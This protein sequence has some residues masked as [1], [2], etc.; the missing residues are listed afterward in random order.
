VKTTVG[1]VNLG[2]GAGKL[3]MSKFDVHN[4]EGFKGK[5]IVSL[6]SA[7]LAVETGS[8][9]GNEVK[10]DSLVLDGLSVDLEQV[11]KRGNFTEILNHIKQLDLKSSSDSQ[12]RLIVKRLVIRDVSAKASLTL[13]GKK[14]FDGSYKIDDITLT[15][16][17]G[18]DGATIAQLTAIVLNNVLIRSVGAA[19][20]N[21]PG[22][23]GTAIEEGAKENLQKLKSEAKDKIKDLGKGLI[24]GGN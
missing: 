13:M 21:L 18:S 5:T 12:Q 8:I 6:K 16:V 17:G 4:P 24:G 23:F 11:D 2:I 22:G 3:D 1:S 14:Q 15:N 20:R 10:V 7:D 9:F 19:K